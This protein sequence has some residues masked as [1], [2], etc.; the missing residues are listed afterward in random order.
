MDSWSVRALVRC[1]MMFVCCWKSVIEKCVMRSEMFAVKSTARVY[2]STDKL[3]NQQQNRARDKILHSSD[4]AKSPPTLHI[5]ILWVLNPLRKSNRK[6]GQHGACDVSNS[7][8]IC[9]SVQRVPVCS[10]KLHK[11]IFESRASSSSRVE[12]RWSSGESHMRKM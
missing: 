9:A 11:V 8:S 10:R 5:T 3:G 7:G 6:D 1:E 2:L 4:K 12:S